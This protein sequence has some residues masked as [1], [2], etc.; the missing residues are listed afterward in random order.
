MGIAIEVLEVDFVRDERDRA[1]GE[2][3]VD[4][5]RMGRAHRVMTWIGRVGAIRRRILG[6][7]PRLDQRASQGIEIPT[8]GPAAVITLAWRRIEIHMDP[9]LRRKDRLTRPVID[10]RKRYLSCEP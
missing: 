6:V 3:R 7:L 9:L 1:V 2:H 5:A 4:A 10:F 8:F